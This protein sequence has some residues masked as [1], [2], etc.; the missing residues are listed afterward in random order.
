MQ[1]LKKTGW[2][3]WLGLV[4]MGCVATPKHSEKPQI[5]ASQPYLEFKMT[6]NYAVYE[7]PSIFLPKSQPTFAIWLQEKGSGMIE[8][9]FVTGKAAEN[10]WILAETRPESIPVWYGVRQTDKVVQ[11]AQIDAISG[12]T[13]SG[14]TVVI[15]WQVPERLRY[16]QV[17]IFIEANSSYDY[18]AYYSDQKDAPGYSGA[19]GQPSLVWKADLDLSKTLD[20][21]IVPEIIGHGH[22]WGKDH[23]IYADISQ[24]TTAR[25]TFSYMA[26]QFFR[27]N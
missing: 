13:P 2:M 8:T 11:G 19:N 20:E 15:Q 16:R 18:N 7:K 23:K 1:R 26:I 14:D 17:S 12:A 5:D 3:V 24:V 6:Y 10:K 27:G 21:E 25:E 4:L 22:L 9:I